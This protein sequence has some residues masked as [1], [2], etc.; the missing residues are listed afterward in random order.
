[1]KM[2]VINTSNSNNRNL[3][4]FTNIIISVIT[5]M[6][7]TIENIISLWVVIVIIQNDDKDKNTNNI[8]LLLFSFNSNITINNW[9]INMNNI[10][11]LE[12]DSLVY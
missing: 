1:M 10:N 8:V 6:G 4:T 7:V 12:S 9:N 11:D 2:V 3:Y 5:S